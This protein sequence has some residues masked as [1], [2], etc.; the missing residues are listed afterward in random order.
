MHTNG[1]RP[2]ST[3]LRWHRW[4]QHAVAQWHL[5]PEAAVQDYTLVHVPPSSREGF[6]EAAALFLA[7]GRFESQGLR[8]LDHP[9]A[10]PAL[11]EAQAAWHAWCT[12]TRR[13]TAYLDRLASGREGT[14]PPVPEALRDLLNTCG[15]MN[16]A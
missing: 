2:S 12:W 16:D 11:H 8:L 13:F 3:S 9:D 5:P 15:D 4:Q 6:F 10:M 1:Q 7:R 14:C